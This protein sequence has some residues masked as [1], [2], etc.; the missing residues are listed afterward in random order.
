MDAPTTVIL[1]EG[2]SDQIA[3]ETLARAEGRDVETWETAVVP[4]G[5][6]QGIGRYAA[7]FGPAGDGL[8]VVVMCD[9]GEERVVRRALGRAGDEVPVFVC[10]LDLE[11][12]LIRAVT[13]DRVLDLL[14]RDD[15]LGSFRTL[16]NQ[17]VWRD[18]PLPS[19]LR[20]FFGSGAT[21]KSRYAEQL[22]LAAVALGRV[23][24]PLRG[25]LDASS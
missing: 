5:G 15:N 6:A 4:T 17:P 20:R 14:A 7:R 25:V 8:R 2:V 9:A 1:V 19:Q 18:Q 13:P 23:P 12:E 16:Q 22:V 21:R 24:A 3:I 11:D 10:Q